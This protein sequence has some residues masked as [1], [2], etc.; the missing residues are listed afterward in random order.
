MKATFSVLLWALLV[1]SPASALI[2]VDLT[3]EGVPS[4]SHSHGSGN[5]PATN[6]VDGM[7][8]TTTHTDSGA[9]GAAFYLDFPEEKAIVQITIIPRVEC[10]G[11]RLNGTKL[12]LFDDENEEVYVADVVDTGPGQAIIFDIPEGTMASNIELGFGSSESG[13]VSVAE[14]QVSGNGG[15]LPVISQFSQTDQGGGDYLLEWNTADGDTVQI[16]GAGTVAASGQTIVSPTQSTIYVLSATNECGTAYQ[17]QV[18]EIGGQEIGLLIS[19]FVANDPGDPDWVEIWNPTSSAI[20][21]TGYFLTDDPDDLAKFPLTAG[22]LAANGFLTIDDPFG[23]SSKADSYIALID[24]SGAVVAEFTYPEQFKLRSYGLDTQLQPTYFTTPTKGEFN[25]SPTTLGVLKGVDFSHKRGFYDAAF[26]LTLSP[27][28]DGAAIYY[29]LDSTAPTAATGTLYTGPITITGT[30]VVRV[31]EH[32]DGF[33]PSD[34]RANTFLFLNQVVQQPANPAGYPTNWQPP[35]RNGALDPIPQPTDYAMDTRVSLGGPYTDENGDSF[36][37]QDA[38]RAIPTMCIS[39]PIAD[40]WDLDVGIHPNANQRGRQWEK[41]ASFE[42]FDPRTGEDFETG[43]GFR[44]HGGRARVPEIMKKSFRVYFRAQYGDSSLERDI[45]TV[46]P[47]EGFDHLVLRGGTGKSWVATHVDE[48]GHERVTFLRD[49]FHRRC[50][51]DMGN[52]SIGGNFVHLYINGL[53]WGLYNNVERP[54]ADQPANHAGHDRD[55]YDVIKLANQ[56]LS[57]AD[58]S[59]ERWEDL[60]ALSR[61]TLTNERYQQITGLVD[62]DNLIDYILTNFYVGNQDWITNNGYGYSRR[63]G[64]DI[65]WKFLPW[66]GEETFRSVGRDSTTR[67]EGRDTTI[68]PLGLHNEL[69]GHPEYRLR[70]A[71]RAYKH[72]L[73]EGGELTPAVATAR[74][75]RLVSEIDRAIVGESARWGDLLRPAQP[76]TREN[77]WLSE[78]Q[79]QRDAYLTQRSLITFTQIDARGLYPDTPPPQ[80]SLVSSTNEL[81]IDPAPG[82]EGTIY[83]TMDGS[84]PREFGGAVSPNALTF[85]S[86]TSSEVLVE[87]GTTQWRY[88]DDRS[89]LGPSNQPLAGSWRSAAFDDS[90]WGSGPGPLGGGSIANTVLGTTVD[91]GPQGNRHITTYF[92]TKFTVDSLTNATSADASIAYDDGVILYLNGTEVWRSPTMP[93]GVITST[94]TTVGTVG[95][96]QE[97]T[98]T[99]ISLPLSAFI[100]GENTL[101]AEVHQ[102]AATSG[103]LGF[104]AIVSLTGTSTSNSEITLTGDTLVRS[105]TRSPSGEW[106]AMEEEFFEISDPEQSLVVTKIMYNPAPLTQADTDAGFTSSKQFEYLEITNVGA[107]GVSTT[108]LR[109]TKGVDYDFPPNLTIEP[110]QRIILA[111][112]AS[113]FAHRYSTDNATVFAVWEDGDSLSNG[114]ERIRLVNGDTESIRDF[115]YDDVSPWPT[116]VEETGLALVLRRPETVPDHSLGINW[117]ASRLTTTL[118]G[119][120][121]RRIYDPSETSLLEYATGSATPSTLLQAAE[122][123]GFR[124]GIPRDLSAEDVDIVIERSLTLGLGTWQVVDD[125]VAD[126]IT[127]GENGDILHFRD[128]ENLDG[129]KAFY[130]FKIEARD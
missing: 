60:L 21:T 16:S 24:P 81:V 93:S 94:T 6:A 101:A 40:M 44:L 70:F 19:E 124:I 111:A 66:D 104:D 88:L 115:E 80:A 68:A 119:V 69:S 13:I 120:D 27:K 102:R 10:C 9:P 20:D 85:A 127:R 51:E 91:I 23:I 98:Y 126:G 77:A 45:F 78:V 79:L 112:D 4:Q 103:D 76:Y 63:I 8:S 89:D 29:T 56:R 113:A 39:L 52:L 130:R 114:G 11:G 129:D 49:E 43:V 34:V 100:E 46:S 67:T 117:R 2:L 82:G 5:F 50:F 41:F 71:D 73:D 92:R 48:A 55:E 59:V 64:D 74:M 3:P 12:R 65:R 83:Y 96:A 84:D 42:Y 22:V 72:L 58:G 107:F 31:I 90:A 32:M 35:G 108:G 62:I 38:L 14:I 15:E 87:S 1:L 116:T 97:G 128:P 109:L 53:Y 33:I 7:T 26:S 106:S 37:T 123:G 47:R 125:V 121:D 25:G 110:G 17:S 57:A 86:G 30:T 18:I 54:G 36:T 99:A 118:P 122:G 28:T 95:S 105:R 75:N 61:Q